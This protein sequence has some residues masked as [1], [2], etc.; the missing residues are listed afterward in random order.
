[1]HSSFA[2]NVN[3]MNV[4]PNTEGGNEGGDNEGILDKGYKGEGLHSSIGRNRATI[5]S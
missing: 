1:M 4:A 3:L 5:S 2:N